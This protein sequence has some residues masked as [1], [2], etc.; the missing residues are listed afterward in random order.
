MTNILATSKVG[1]TFLNK[2]QDLQKS[3]PSQKNEAKAVKHR[4]F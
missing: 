4:F 2:F 3:S 1:I